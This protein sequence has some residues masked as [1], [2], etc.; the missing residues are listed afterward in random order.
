M[1]S[2]KMSSSRRRS[3]FSDVSRSPTTDP[4]VVH[5][6]VSTF[7]RRTMRRVRIQVGHEYVVL[8]L[9][10]NAK[11]HRGRPCVI[12]ELDD[13]FMPHQAAVQFTDERG[14]IAKVLCGDLAEPSSPVLHS[15]SVK[16][17][18]LEEIQRRGGHL[19]T[20]LAENLTNSR[21]SELK[22]LIKKMEM[23]KEKDPSC[24]P[25]VDSVFAEVLGGYAAGVARATGRE[26]RE[27]LAEVIWGAKK[28]LMH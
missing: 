5:E 24:A 26:V 23:L 19:A 17:W 21:L 4:D 10:P 14:R 16:H 1:P 28:L 7:G 11:R 25:Q 9:N 18:G 12:V 13:E 3:M 6:V 8:P 27:I 22:R 20:R 2:R 15:N